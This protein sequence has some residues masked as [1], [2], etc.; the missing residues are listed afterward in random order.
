MPLSRRPRLPSPNSL[1]AVFTLAAAAITTGCGSRDTLGTDA[2][3]AS[4]PGAPVEVDCGRLDRY[5]A[6]RQALELMAE[7]ASES[8]LVSIGWSIAEGPEDPAAE[9]A[10]DVGP[11]AIFT[12]TVAGTFQLEF[13]AVNADGL[14]G[15]CQVTVESVVGPP[16]AICPPDDEGERIETALFAP[17]LIQG[18]GVDDDGVVAYQ[19]DLA[20]GV[21]DAEV[22]ILPRTEAITQF[23]ADQP[24]EYLLRLT[25]YDR[26]G[27]S[28]ACFVPVFV[29]ARP[30]VICPEGPLE[31]PTRTPFAF[32][33]TI[34][35]DGGIVRESWEVVEAPD[36]STA[37]PRPADQR[38]TSITLNRRGEHRLRFTVEDRSGFE[39]SCE[40][41]LIGTDTPPDLTCPDQVETRPLNRV[42]VT[43]T[44][45][46]D[47]EL[48]S[49]S[50]RV[51]DAPEF[52]AADSPSPFDR[53]ETNFT[54]DIAGTYR[55]ELTVS[56]DAGNE[57]RCQTDVLAIATEGL[58]VEMFW[59]TSGTD[60]DLHLLHPDATRWN[61]GLD[62]YYANCDGFE[63]LNWFSSGSEDDPRLDIDDVDGFG[64]EN[65]NIEE[66]A[67]GTYR[68][69]VHSFRGSGRVTVRIYCGG[70]TTEPRA[71]FG[72]TRLGQTDLLWRVADVTIRGTTCEIAELGRVSDYARS[73]EPR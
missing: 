5:T 61:G 22:T 48:R 46:D 57:A 43:A 1:I 4:R 49:A 16:V 20:R 41:T 30:T 56:D 29:T 17:V 67:D 13:L 7:V 63:R 18:D 35:N 71:T 39:D 60:M 59:D 73:S 64:P 25:V 54:P 47:G 19:W 12:P 24:G 68:V 70:S 50:W 38:E 72:P 34:E 40:V 52:S 11:S 15:V 8:P 69:G 33:A 36:G 44:F 9:L 6:P 26:E 14:E 53:L 27:A 65:I 42:G 31:T 2:P 28:D 3:D 55:L 37:A 45:V 51:I 21:A 66:P 23:S 62:C 58:R 32:A 10:P